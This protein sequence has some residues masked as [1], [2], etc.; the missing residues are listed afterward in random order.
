ME[1]SV[2][3][4]TF[5]GDWTGQSSRWPVPQ[6]RARFLG[7]NLGPTVLRRACQVGAG[8][9]FLASHSRGCPALVAFSATEPALSGAE[10]A[11]ILTSYRRAPRL[12]LSRSSIGNHRRDWRR[13]QRIRRV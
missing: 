5:R 3:R 12:A 2:T 6:V 4:I 1:K 7:A 11:G 8:P 10:G 13:R 9:P